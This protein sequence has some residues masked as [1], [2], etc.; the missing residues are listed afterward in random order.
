MA[1][2]L[3]SGAPAVAAKA[4]EYQQQEFDPNQSMNSNEDLA[5][6]EAIFGDASDVLGRQTAQDASKQRLM[7]E[8]PDGKAVQISAHEAEQAADPAHAMDSD[9]QEPSNTAVEKYSDSLQN[10]ADLSNAAEFADHENNHGATS[11]HVHQVSP[12]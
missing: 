6:A 5:L 12:L 10:L 7:S 8:R 11:T 1:S 2:V 4:T 3:L 9:A